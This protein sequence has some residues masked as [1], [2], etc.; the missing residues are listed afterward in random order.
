MTYSFGGENLTQTILQHIYETDDP[1]LS[2][3]KRYVARDATVDRLEDVKPQFCLIFFSAGF[4]IEMDIH[5]EMMRRPAT[6]STSRSLPTIMNKPTASSPRVFRYNKTVDAEVVVACPDM[7]IDW[8]ISV[9]SDLSADKVHDKYRE[10]ATSLRFDPVPE[11]TLTFPVGT[12]SRQA[13]LRANIDG[14]ACKV[15]RTVECVNAPYLVEIAAYYDW[16]STP[17]AKALTN[18]GRDNYTFDTAGQRSPAPSKSCAVAL[19]D[20]DWDAKMRNTNP[21]SGPFAEELIDIFY[22][23]DQLAGC[24][25]QI[26]GELSAGQLLREVEFLLDITTQAATELE[27]LENDTQHSN[28]PASVPAGDATQAVSGPEVPTQEA[29]EAESLLDFGAQPEDTESLLDF[30]DHQAEVESLIDVRSHAETESLLDFSAQ[31]DAR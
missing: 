30:N 12:V 16:N 18:P 2:D 6:T 27:S 21:T 3:F 19:Y 4:R 26:A 9:E 13:L 29:T 23:R 15:Y 20:E 1:E 25:S 11:G 8:Q 5:F 10:L 22:N 17:L 24:G 31:P 28:N 14:A 7:K